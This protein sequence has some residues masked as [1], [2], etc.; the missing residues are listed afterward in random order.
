[1]QQTNPPFQ[2][3]GPSLSGS[4][5]P[6]A[7]GLQQLLLR[8]HQQ[9]LL[10]QQQPPPPQ[11]QQQQQMQQYATEKGRPVINFWINNF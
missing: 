7:Q 10:Q 9:Q 11:Q 5:I 1:M 6:D 4:T 2:V 3:Y 8:Y